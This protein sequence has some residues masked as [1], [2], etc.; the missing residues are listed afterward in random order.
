MFKRLGCH[1]MLRV[2]T[3]DILIHILTRNM[4]MEQSYSK[5]AIN[6]LGN[7]LKIRLQEKV[8]FGLWMEIFMR[9]NGKMGKLKNLGCSKV[10]MEVNILDNGRM[11]YN[12][13]K[14]QKIGQTEVYILDIMKKEWNQVKVCTNILMEVNMMD[15]GKIM[16]WME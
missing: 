10:A 3:Q 5:M 6:I 15:N 2:Y 16:K 12:T 11:I 7:G 14:D 8:N 9:V 13:V 4:D 1:R